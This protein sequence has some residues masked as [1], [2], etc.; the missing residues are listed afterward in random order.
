LSKK[1]NILTIAGSDPLSK[2]GIMADFGVGYDLGA[3]IFN[4]ITAINAQNNQEIRNIL[5]LDRKIIKDQLEVIFSANKI[6]LVKIG[7]V[8]N[9]SSV[10]EI[11]D[12]LTTK[13]IKIIFDPV[14]KASNGYNLISSEAIAEIKLKLIANC[15]LVTPNIYELEILS[16]I[17]IKN[18]D[19]I[20]KAVKNLKNFGV[21][22]ILVKGGH[23][24]EKS[25][26]VLSFL[27]SDNKIIKL[28]NK[29]LNKNCRGTGCMLSTAIAIFLGNNYNLLDAVKKSN[30][31]VYHKIKSY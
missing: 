10:K 15:Y 22:N 7:M 25:D 16:G 17:K 18:F 29:R 26:K 19:D 4:S 9:S 5:Y 20:A 28:Q 21:S 8:G 31:Y 14:I 13:N 30:K 2:S 23:F 11:I 27:F 24:Q 6:D 3:N 12:F 1:P